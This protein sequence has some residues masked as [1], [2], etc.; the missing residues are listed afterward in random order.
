MNLVLANTTQYLF[1]SI[2]AVSP[3]IFSEVITVAV[4]NYWA[5]LK[6]LIIH[7]DNNLISS[8]H[9]LKFRTTEILSRVW[10]KSLNVNFRTKC[11]IFAEFFRSCTFPCLFHNTLSFQLLWNKQEKGKLGRL[12]FLACSTL[13]IGYY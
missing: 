5:Y 3:S 9:L 11:F 8:S 10:K 2:T 1:R 6:Q 7:N 13:I 12:Y 4:N